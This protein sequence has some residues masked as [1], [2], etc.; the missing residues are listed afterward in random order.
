[1]NTGKVL[2]CP[3]LFEHDL[4]KGELQ[5][6][7]VHANKNIFPFFIFGGP[8]S[9]RRQPSPCWMAN[10]ITLRFSSS[11]LY[12]PTGSVHHPSLGALLPRL[13]LHSTTLLILYLTSSVSSLVFDKVSAAVDV[14]LRV[15]TDQNR[16]CGMYDMRWN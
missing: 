6:V 5:M 3:K 11:T 4:S 9:D 13:V 16:P 8:M 7:W 10:I 15:V 1:M 14:D 2:R 12:I